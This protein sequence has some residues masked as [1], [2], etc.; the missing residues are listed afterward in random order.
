MQARSLF[1]TLATALLA[2]TALAQTVWTPPGFAT[3]PGSS[4]NIYPWGRNASATHY[5]QIYGAANF[6]MQGINAAVVITRLRFRSWA[7][8]ASWAGGNWPNVTLNMS[9][10]ALPFT[11]ASGVFAS[12]HGGDLT[13]V[14]TGTVTVLPG[15]G[16]GATLPGPVYI[17]IPLTTPFLYN[18]TTGDL[19][20]EV[21]LPGVGWTGVS[22]PCDAVSGAAAPMTRIYELSSATSTTGTVGLNYGLVT[23]FTCQSPVGFATRGN[24]GAGCYSSAVSFYENFTGAPTFDLGGS[25]TTVNTI[26]MIPNG[27]GGY[28]V[29]PGGNTWTTPV[30][31]NLGLG[32]D[33]QT[34]PLA[35]PFSFPYPG[36]STGSIIVCSNGLVGLDATGGSVTGYPST[37][38]L[39]SEGAR[40]AAYWTDLDPSSATGA[41]SVTLDTTGSDATITWSNV[42]MWEAVPSS[43][44]FLSTFQ[45]VLQQ[46]GI[47][48]FRYQACS[49]PATAGLNVLVGFS[50]GAGARDPGNRDLSTSLPFNTMTDR[51]ALALNASAR[52]VIGTSINLTTSN[53][54]SGT[55][56]GASI[57]SF[58][59]HNPGLDLTS[60]GMAGCRQFVGLDASTVFVVSGPSSVRALAIPGNNAL[61]GL[62][63]YSQSATFTIGVNP[64]GVLASNGVALALDIN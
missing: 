8:A 13:N 49:A 1:A 27:Q 56:V 57:L 29:I 19:C 43:P 2:T 54:P 45:I 47:V 26:M 33:T 64:L 36:G 4:N 42:A 3:T 20:F 32:D 14:Y 9:T 24:Y 44:R 58:T 37:G 15:T 28:T 38:T 34:A 12:N 10:A 6:T 30:A 50:P 39:L 48:E 41:G 5:Q 52:P 23:E 21:Q 59:Q 60:I 11:A 7:T 40:L 51:T 53:I 46:S 35:L 55:A 17:D 18:P 63:V 31:A 25:A 62:R 61:A 22:Q 16:N